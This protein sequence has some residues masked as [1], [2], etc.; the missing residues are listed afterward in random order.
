MDGS[1]R[2]RIFIILSSGAKVFSL[3]LRYMV[4]KSSE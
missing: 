2:D 3:P 4:Y 1:Q